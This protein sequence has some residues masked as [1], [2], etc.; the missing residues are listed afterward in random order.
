MK[1]IWEK[2]EL[3]DKTQILAEKMGHKAL[4]ELP[5]AKTLVSKPERY[6]KTTLRLRYK[7]ATDVLTHE[8]VVPFTFAFQVVFRSVHKPM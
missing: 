8:M 4:V 3:T 7:K 6:L 5:N 1:S 2:L